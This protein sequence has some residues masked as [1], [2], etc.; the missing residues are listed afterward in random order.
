MANEVTKELVDALAANAFAVIGSAVTAAKR[1]N[2][3]AITITNLLGT[4]QTVRLR[5][6]PT[7]YAVYDVVIAAGQSLV[8]TGL[9]AVMA[10]GEQ[11][12]AVTTTA[13][14]VSILVTGVEEDA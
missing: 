5:L 7:S 11:C 1:F 4:S 2:V 13:S 10:A 9:L 3:K 12:S 14:G 8:M 6:G